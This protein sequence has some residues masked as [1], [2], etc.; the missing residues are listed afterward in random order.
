MV[1]IVVSVGVDGGCGVVVLF[2]AGC[3]GLVV[4]TGPKVGGAGVV[5][6]TRSIIVFDSQVTHI[7]HRVQCMDVCE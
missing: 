6:L 1:P 7:N 4:V 2:I 5:G 3:S